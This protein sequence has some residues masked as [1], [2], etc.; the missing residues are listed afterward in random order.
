[1]LAKIR[2]VNNGTGDADN[3][4]VTVL[5]DGEP[6]ATTTVSV[7]AKAERFVYFPVLRGYNATVRLDSKNMINESDETNN[8]VTKPS[9]ITSR[10]H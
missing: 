7:A 6:C 5:L 3:F 2:V 1:M 8:E 9:T 10:R 4:E